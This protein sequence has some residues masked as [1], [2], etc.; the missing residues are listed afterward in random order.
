[1]ESEHDSILYGCRADRSG[2]RFWPGQ[3]R[4]R[5]GP[6]DRL[7]GRRCRVAVL[8]DGPSASVR[9][10]SEMR[11][12][13]MNEPDDIQWLKDTALKGVPLPKPYNGFRAFVL[14]GN[15]DAPHAVDLYRNAAPDY[16]DDFYRVRFPSDES[17]VYAEG[18]EYNGRTNR[19]FGGFKELT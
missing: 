3:S 11:V 13:F 12:Q 4:M 7:P 15:E 14:E 9:T 2:M 1:M 5:V 6:D 10:G 16:N 17:M 19:P 18:L 8:D